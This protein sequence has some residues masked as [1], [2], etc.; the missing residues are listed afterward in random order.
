MQGCISGNGIGALDPAKSSLSNGPDVERSCQLSISKSRLIKA[1]RLRKSPRFIEASRGPLTSN[2]CQTQPEKRPTNAHVNTHTHTHTH[3]GRAHARRVFTWREGRKEGKLG[4]TL[5]PGNTT[6]SRYIQAEPT[7]NLVPRRRG[8][9]RGRSTSEEPR[10]ADTWKVEGRAVQRGRERERKRGG[11]NQDQKAS[12]AT[13][14]CLRP[15]PFASTP[16]PVLFHHSGP[17][18]LCIP[19]S[20]STVAGP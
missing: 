1:I 16:S 14:Y 5:S 2:R 10:R 6:N 9:G 18:L 13:D 3:T 17:F 8:R 20:R 4:V 15:T 11:F 12:G 19:I 7:I